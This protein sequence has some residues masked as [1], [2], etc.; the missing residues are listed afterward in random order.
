MIFVYNIKEINV[1]T[2]NDFV[3][4]VNYAAENTSQ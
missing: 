2:K 1:I 3:P 4:K